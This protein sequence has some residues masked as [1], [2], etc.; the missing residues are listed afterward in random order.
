MLSYH[1]QL[2][3]P[4]DFIKPSN[5]PAYFLLARRIINSVLSISFPHWSSENC[6]LHTTYCTQP[7]VTAI[8]HQ[9]QCLSEIIH[10]GLKHFHTL[11]PVSSLPKNLECDL[12][13]SSLEWRSDFRLRE[14]GWEKQ[15]WEDRKWILTIFESL[16]PFNSQ[17][18]ATF[19]PLGVSVTFCSS[20]LLLK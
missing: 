7:I 13:N 18:P 10:P 3:I 14:E 4:S 20:P 2:K 9:Q 8:C 11:W 17:D 19:Q 6:L 1:L 12:S 15:S 5:Y 16:F